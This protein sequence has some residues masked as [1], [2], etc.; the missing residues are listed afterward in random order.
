M[1]A[2]TVD[3]EF[4]IGLQ[5][6]AP[7]SN[8]WI[9]VCDTAKARFFELRSGNPSWH[10]IEVLTHD[11]SRR[12]SSDLASDHSG[13]R[14]SQGASVHHNALAPASSPKEVEKGHFV[15]ALATRLDQA[16]RSDRFDGWVLVAPPHV[17][18][19]MKKELTPQL[20]KRLLNTV[21]EDLNQFDVQELM[22]RLAAA[23]CLPLGRKGAPRGIPMK[24]H[25]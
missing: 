19:M 22:T 11:G 21:G 17:V 16:M 12:K 10:V 3:A 7:M 4:S 25:S 18:G 5:G 2:F 24:A 20:T 23:V 6:D 9:L 15:H 13:R 1:H 14:S 8:V